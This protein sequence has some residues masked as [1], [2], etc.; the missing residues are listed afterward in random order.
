MAPTVKNIA[1][2]Q[3]TKVSLDFIPI[4]STMSFPRRNHPGD[5]ANARVASIQVVLLV[6]GPIA[7]FDEL[8]GPDTHAVADRPENLAIPVQLQELAILS[9]RHPGLA[10][11]VEIQRAHEVSHLHRLEER[12]IR[13]ID[14]DAIFLAVADPDV[15][16]C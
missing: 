7:G 5:T 3:H 9:G 16:G 2:A 13:G 15:A 11:R 14:D 12:A 4:L 10:V 8:P 6:H 1:N